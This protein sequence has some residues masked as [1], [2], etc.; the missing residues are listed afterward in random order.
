M[1][2][3]AGKDGF[4]NFEKRQALQESHSLLLPIGEEAESVLV[5][6]NITADE[7]GQYAAVVL[8]RFS[9]YARQTRLGRRCGREKHSS[10]RRGMLAQRSYSAVCFKKSVSSVQQEDDDSLSDNAFVD[11]V[12]QREKESWTSWLERT[13]GYFIGI[14]SSTVH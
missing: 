10:V 3:R 11:A 12:S 7:R 1:T 6:S 9:K 13:L 2:G 5:S 4:N 8:M 14:I